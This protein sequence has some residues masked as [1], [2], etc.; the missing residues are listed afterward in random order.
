MESAS[1]GRWSRLQPVLAYLSRHRL[2]VIV[3]LVAFLVRFIYLL[4]Y[5]ES[6]FF[7]VHI[8]DAL[9]HEQ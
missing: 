2:S 4:D 3:L 7:Q 1:T 6:P 8:A 9:Y 5:S